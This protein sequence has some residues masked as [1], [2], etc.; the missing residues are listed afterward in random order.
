MD[1]DRLRLGV[2]TFASCD[3]CQL[4]LLGGGLLAA[5]AERFVIVHFAELGPRAPAA[6][7]DLALVEGSVSTAADIERLREVR[8]RSGY[9]VALGNCATSGGLQSLRGLAVDGGQWVADLYPHPEWVDL[10]AAPTPLSRHVRVDFELWGCPVDARQLAR[11]LCERGAGVAARPERRSVCAECKAQ[12]VACLLVAGGAPCMGPLTRAGCGALCPRLGRACYA[13]FGPAD[14][15]NVPALT[16]RFAAL[17]LSGEAVA[18]QLRFV[19][20]DVAAFRHG[21]PGGSP[22]GGP[23]TP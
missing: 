18:R 3:G 9:L 19:A 14:L 17:G 6:P 11:F 16:E 13:C 8:A 10:L 15:A 4:V 1:L 7:V 23:E 5:L 12:C 20:G 22:A 21:A 2:Y